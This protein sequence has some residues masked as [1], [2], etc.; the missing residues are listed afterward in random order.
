[1]SVS[2]AQNTLGRLHSHSEKGAAHTMKHNL[3]RRGLPSSMP[4][5][6]FTHQHEEAEWSSPALYISL[7][8]C[9]PIAK[10]QFMEVTEDATHKR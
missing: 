3:E 5:H 9:F 6:I 1:M 7:A 8:M 2:S 10:R 4:E